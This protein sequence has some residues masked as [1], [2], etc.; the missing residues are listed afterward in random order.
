MPF[1]V[2]SEFSTLTAGELLASP[3]SALIGVQPDVVQLLARL[4]VQTIGD[5]ADSML[6]GT[7]T[8][9]VQLRRR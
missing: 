9:I 1:S 7:A 3:S 8:L 2:R 6:F 4:G 5:L